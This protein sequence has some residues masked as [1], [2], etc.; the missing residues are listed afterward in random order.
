MTPDEIDSL[1]VGDGLLVRA[2]LVKKGPD[3]HL[4]VELPSSLPIFVS[5]FDVHSKTVAWEFKLGDEVQ[6]AS[7][8]RGILTVMGKYSSCITL[9]SGEPWTLPTDKLQHATPET[10]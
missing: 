1:K 9:E 10:R 6:T 5:R 4:C 7:G 8:K 2:T 3:G